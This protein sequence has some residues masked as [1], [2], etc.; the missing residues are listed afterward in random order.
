MNSKIRKNKIV[1]LKCLGD[2]SYL[3]NVLSMDT[4]IKN[5]TIIITISTFRCIIFKIIKI[6]FLNKIFRRK[7][8]SLIHYILNSKI[9]E[10]KN[11]CAYFNLTKCH[12]KLGIIIL[13]NFT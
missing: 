2:V 1:H 12:K 11:L 6:I 10:K 13:I 9:R 4:L 8:I 3:S 5:P 7:A